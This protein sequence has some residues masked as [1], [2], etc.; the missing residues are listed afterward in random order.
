MHRRAQYSGFQDLERRAMYI[1]VRGYAEYRIYGFAA[2][3]PVQL[4]ALFFDEMIGMTPLSHSGQSKTFEEYSV[5]FGCPFRNAAYENLPPQVMVC[6]ANSVL[7]VRIW[8]LS[9]KFGMSQWKYH[10]AKQ[11]VLMNQFRFR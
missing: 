10:P 4:S 9:R 8:K 3:G 5:F 2:F 7:R 6:S 11:R 1:S